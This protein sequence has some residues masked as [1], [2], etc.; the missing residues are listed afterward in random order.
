[1]TSMKRPA[2]CVKKRPAA[3]GPSGGNADRDLKRLR[4]KAKEHGYKLRRIEHVELQE[5]RQLSFLR[6]RAMAAG[7]LL[8]KIDDSE[9]D[10]VPEDGG[11]SKDAKFHTILGG[12][13][14]NEPAV[15]GKFKRRMAAT[16]LTDKDKVTSSE[17]VPD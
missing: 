4:A 2:A 9:S 1:M 15:A 17:E 10:S 7:W 12:G 5:P 13:T 16:V 14:S 3:S 6:A 8:E 11:K